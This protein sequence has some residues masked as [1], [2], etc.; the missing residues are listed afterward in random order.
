METTDDGFT[1]DTAKSDRINEVLAKL[2][3]QIIDPNDGCEQVGL[4]EGGDVTDDTFEFEYFEAEKY[5]MPEMP[6]EKVERAQELKRVNGKW[7]LVTL[8]EEE[9]KK[10]PYEI[11]NHKTSQ[12]TKGL[13]EKKKWEK[14]ESEMSNWEL[15]Q[16]NK[17]SK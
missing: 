13:G 12:D 2:K 3:E 7:K 4:R 1:K 17:K 11:K 8:S 15:M 6:D 14:P 10:I 16:K 5:D 9:T